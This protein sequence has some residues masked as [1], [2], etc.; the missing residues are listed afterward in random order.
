[1]QSR[2]AAVLRREWGDRPCSHPRFEKEHDINAW[3]GAHVC[4]QCGRTFSPGDVAH[5]EMMRAMYYPARG[6]DLKEPE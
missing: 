2:R 4:A 3:T 1:M 6:K 5:I